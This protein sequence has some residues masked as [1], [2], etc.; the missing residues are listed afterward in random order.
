MKKL[1]TL[2]LATSKHGHR[3]LTTD[4]YV[5]E[6]SQPSLLFEPHPVL[7]A[8]RYTEIDDEDYCNLAVMLKEGRLY[9]KEQGK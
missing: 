9:S 7:W 3:Y 1:E 6:P 4:V 5:V 8:R 2:T